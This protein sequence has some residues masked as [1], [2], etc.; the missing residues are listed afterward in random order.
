MSDWHLHEL[1]VAR[2]AAEI[3][4][5]GV[6]VMGSFTPLAH[7]AYML[8]K[9]T[10]APGA[11][12]VGFDAV[13]M[14]PIE[15]SIAG[16]EAAAYRGAVGRWSS[17]VELNGIHLANRGGVEAV[18]SAQFD[19]SGAINLSVIGDF[20]HPKVRLPGGAAAPEVVRRYRRMVAYFPRHD[21][22]TLVAEVDFVSGTR[23]PVGPD[24]RRAAGLLPGPMV[25]ITELAVLQTEAA[26]VPWQIVSVHP[27]VEAATVVERT[28]FE[29][30]EAD[31]MTETA[32]PT[33][34]QL[35]VLR[36][37][38][39]P[40]GVVELEFLRGPEREARLDAVLD[41]EWQ[42]AARRAGVQPS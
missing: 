13:G 5:A 18:S 36:E 29:V 41:A 9:H 35:S 25:L 21:S 19:G 23:G 24:E 26:G 22:R 17:A 31:D 15:L 39:D 42:R 10:H 3:E 4:P 34:E 37:R 30:V 7:A 40:L 6:V 27:G 33:H 38:V 11:Y 8:A 12:L 32:V 2:L 20:D 1:V 16:S 14:A 28:G